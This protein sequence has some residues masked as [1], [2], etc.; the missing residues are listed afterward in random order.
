MGRPRDYQLVRNKNRYLV[1]QTLW[2]RAPVT[3]EEIASL[4]GLSNPT[5]QAALRD[6]NC[7]GLL[8]EVNRRESTGGRPAAELALN[9]DAAYALAAWLS[10][11][12]MRAAVLDL[13]GNIVATAECR[14]ARETD[15]STVL[16]LLSGMLRDVATRVGIRRERICGIGIA[17]SGVVDAPRGVSV[18]IERLQEWRQVAIGEYLDRQF[19]LPVIL[20]ADTQSALAAELVL[21]M[22]R[23]PGR[24]PP[25]SALFILIRDGLGDAL[26]INGRLHNGS[27]GNAGFMGHM[28]L[29][30][31]GP[32][33]TCS[34]RGCLE[35]YVSELAIIRGVSK[36][37]AV[38]ETSSLLTTGSVS[39][40]Q[41][42][43]AYQQGDPLV[44]QVMEAAADRLAL[45]IANAIK[46][47][48]PELVILYTSTLYTNETILVRLTAACERYLARMQTD[49]V[50]IVPASVDCDAELKGVGIITLERAVANALALAPN[51]GLMEAVE[52][53]LLA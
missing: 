23:S 22:R 32:V 4:T 12:T 53:T 31:E 24:V 41:I 40:D 52:S 30:P 35:T 19:G 39:I 10:V 43:V 3:R 18:S 13:C 45:G 47:V 46:L 37:L 48:Q 16:A 29:D 27:H 33:C 9:P 28:C 14:L 8:S 6:F 50:I 20:M 38:G 21:G 17:A 7:R 49:P 34:A 11:P 15:T 1:L 36:R 44:M 2:N 42:E 25:Q 26:I 51:H 5:V